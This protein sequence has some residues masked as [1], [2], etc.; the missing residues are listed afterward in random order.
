MSLPK[1]T[2]DPVGFVGEVPDYEGNSGYVESF[3]EQWLRHQRTQLDSH[4]GFSIT[5]DRLRRMFGDLIDEI[6]GSLLLE[7][8]SGS[9]RFTEILCKLECEVVSFDL[10]DAVKANYA[11]NGH[12]PNLTIIK[13]SI[14]NLPFAKESFDFVFCPGVVQHTPNP[15]LFLH[16]LFDQVKPGGWLVFDQ[17]R[18]NLASLLRTTGLFRFVLKRVPPKLGFRITDFLVDTL[19]PIHQRVYKIKILESLLFRLSPITAHFSGYPFLSYDQQI[20]WAKLNTHDNLT[21]FHKHMTTLGQLQRR[22]NKL[23][24]INQQ[25]RIM[26]YT[27]EVRVQKPS[28]NHKEDTSKFK[29]EKPRRR[30]VVSG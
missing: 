20:D 24:G 29:V 17:Y 11:N 16:H 14:S 27:I 21:D 9:G 23:G 13:A 8:G 2:R 26:P 10:S 7:V 22:L 6:K 5:S 12:N 28:P 3:G 1:P 25:F 18:Y 19:L 4:T 15:K 30:D